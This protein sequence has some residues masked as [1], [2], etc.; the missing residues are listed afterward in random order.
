MKKSKHR[1]RL[2]GE[3]D[4]SVIGHRPP[5][6]YLD[7]YLRS[8]LPTFTKNQPPIWPPDVFALCMAPLWKSTAYT[9][10]LNHWPPGGVASSEWTKLIRNGARKWRAGWSQKKIP[11]EVASRWREAF[12]DTAFPLLRLP[13]RKRSCELLLELAALADEASAGLGIPSEGIEESIDEILFAVEGYERLRKTA[14]GGSTLCSVIDASRAR[15]LPKMHCPQSGLTIRS[16]SHHLAFLF[17][18][19]IKPVWNQWSG[20]DVDYHFN[21]LVVPRPSAVTPNQFRSEVP[22]K[23][24]MSNIDIDH[25]GFFS[26]D[27]LDTCK[28]TIADIMNLLR[29]AKKDC[30]N[31]HGV[32]LP[33]LALSESDYGLLRNKLERKKVFLIAGV[34]T[35][36]SKSRH[37]KNEVRVSFPLYRDAVQRKHHRWKLE[38]RQIT[39]YALGGRLDAEKQWWEHIS[40]EDRTLNFFSLLPWL[41]LTPLVCEDLARPDPVGDLVRA[42]GPNLVIALLM[43]GPQLKERWSARYATTLAD[44]PGSSVLTVTSAGMAKLSR[45]HGSAP[46]RDPVIALWK[47]A[48]SGNQ[49]EI[50]LPDG[51]DGVVLS[52]SR[53]YAEEWSADGRSDGGT[54]GYP[55]L[56]GIF[57][58]KL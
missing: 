7:E 16:L 42:V 20:L 40:V 35:P 11:S 34:G 17:S 13:E 41:V 1:P 31:I 56:T 58:V 29:S 27:H 4:S 23:G 8:I 24:E 48:K 25:F 21:L 30:G 36:G 19:E 2:I 33:E 50:S 28:P 6:L 3:E 37:A 49:V 39:Q 32:V 51:Y 38:E 26:F 57:P 54:S 45:P 55:S 47:D 15:V 10:V 14:K 53:R 43:D 46:S 44:D 52:L 5:P 22:L 18:D 12:H 9:S